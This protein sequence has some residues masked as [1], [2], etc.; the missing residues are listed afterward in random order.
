[1]AVKKKQIAKVGPIS[2]AIQ[3]LAKDLR[4]AEPAPS[5]YFEN[6]PDSKFQATEPEKLMYLA[7]FRIGAALHLRDQVAARAIADEAQREIH[8]KYTYIAQ[9]AFGLT[10]EKVGK[11]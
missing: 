3:K 4:N 7:L 10:F 2:K 9:D 5:R 6:R 8:V 1:M 11:K